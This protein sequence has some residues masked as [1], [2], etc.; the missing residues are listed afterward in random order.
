[1]HNSKTETVVNMEQLREWLESQDFIFD[2]NPYHYPVNNCNWLAWRQSKLLAKDCD[3]NG[4]IHIV[5]VPYSHNYNGQQRDSVEVDI[6]G[7]RDGIWYKLQAYSLTPAE[8]IARLDEIE[9]KLV[10]AW[11]SL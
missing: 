10:K 4:T 7:A 5:L 2:R 8:L 1:M 9:T 3:Y 6:T 11:N